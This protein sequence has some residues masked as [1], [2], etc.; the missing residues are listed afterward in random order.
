MSR[1]IFGVV[2]GIHDGK[3][4]DGEDGIRHK[5]DL[6]LVCILISVVFFAVQIDL[7]NRAPMK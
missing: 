5:G 7:L 2:N 3:I 1:S 6:L 4:F